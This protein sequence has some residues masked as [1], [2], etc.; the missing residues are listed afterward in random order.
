MKNIVALA[1]ND[2]DI[3]E[4]APVDNMTDSDQVCVYHFFIRQNLI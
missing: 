1:R 3:L 4:N 2:E